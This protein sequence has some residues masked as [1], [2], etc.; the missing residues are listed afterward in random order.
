M[1]RVKYLPYG[2]FMSTTVPAIENA[3]TA[4]LGTFGEQRQRLLRESHRVLLPAEGAPAVERLE[5]VAKLSQVLVSSLEELKVAEEELLEQNDE[6]ARSQTEAELRLASARA[7]FELAPVALVLTDRHGAIRQANQAACAL[8]CR[9]AYALERKPLAALV[10]R[11]TRA[12]FREG[13]ARLLTVTEGATDWQ[14]TVERATDV[15]VVV[16]AAVRFVP[17]PALGNA[18]YWSLRPLRVE[19]T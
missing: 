2:D 15:P 16:S 6:L 12:Q 19:V 5:T 10:P 3:V 8:F 7:L 18:L 9:D 11:T 14:F 1:Q 4:S 17:H 13:L